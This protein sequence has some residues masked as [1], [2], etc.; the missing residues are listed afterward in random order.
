MKGT[1]THSKRSS[2]TRRALPAAAIGLGVT[3]GI[4]GASAS[5]SPIA[6]LA[7]SGQAI[8]E[9]TEGNETGL[10]VVGKFTDA[11]NPAVVTN[12]SQ[13]LYSVTIHW[14]DG[15]SNDGV[16]AC[17]HTGQPQANIPNGVFDVAG[18]HIYADSGSYVISLTVT[19]N[20]E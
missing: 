5:T 10:T 7:A 13:S 20:D 2:F 18:N 15:S 6:V 3:A 11:T 14:G 8:S 16:Y 12:C 4:V 9:V 17:E 1:G 19:K